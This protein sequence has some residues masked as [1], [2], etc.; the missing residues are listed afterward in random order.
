MRVLKHL[1][2]TGSLLIIVSLIMCRS[3]IYAFIEEKE[4]LGTLLT[5]ALAVITVSIVQVC[6]YARQKKDHE[7]NALMKS[8]ERRL[9]KKEEVLGL[10]CEM[11]EMLDELCQCQ[12]KI[13]ICPVTVDNME[14]RDK[15]K[16]YINQLTTKF[17][18][19]GNLFIIYLPSLIP[20]YKEF[21]TEF[22]NFRKI[23][24]DVES[25][26]THQSLDKSSSHL[27]SILI[28]LITDVRESPNKL[29]NT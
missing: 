4:L 24:T 23:A 18:L 3:Q 5:G 17:N 8:E 21:K 19:S 25:Y 14:L 15:Y 11:N 9:D 2:A 1:L 10:L 12:H 20:N 28:K 26:T 16:L 29:I 22:T 27:Q 13:F 7:H 6:F